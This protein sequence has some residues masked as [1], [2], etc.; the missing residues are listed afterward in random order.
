MKE[1]LSTNPDTLNKYRTDIV[2]V[3]NSF[4]SY[5]RRKF[6]KASDEVRLIYEEHLRYVRE[7]LLLCLHN[8]NLDYEFSEDKFELVDDDKLIW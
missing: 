5:V 6:D 3:Y 4:I 7:K 1:N 8:L 2:S